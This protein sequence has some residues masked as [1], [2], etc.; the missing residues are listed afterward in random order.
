MKPLSFL[1]RIGLIVILA[2]SFLAGMSTPKPVSA[3]TITVCSSGCDYTTI[4][5][6]VDAANEGDEILVHAGTFVENVT[7]NKNLKLLS[8]EGRFSTTIEGISGVGALATITITGNTTN[9]QIGDLN[10]GF[11]IIGIDN[12]NPAVENAAVYFQGNHSGAIIRGN[13]IVANGD[14][15]LVT[16]WGATIS[17]FE[18]KENIFS[19]KTFVGDNPAG[20]GFGQQFSL[21]NVPRQLVAIGGGATGTGTTNI[22]FR[23]NIVNGIAGG[24]NSSGQPQ[25]NTLVTIDADNS[26]IEGNR[27]EGV[28]SRYATSLRARRPNTTIENNIFSSTGLL[29]SATGHIFLQNNPINADLIA[30]NTFDKGVYVYNTLGGTVGISISAAVIAAPA[31]NVIYVL[32]GIYTEQVVIEKDLTLMGSGENTII[33]SPGTL[34]STYLIGSN[35]YKPVILVKDA[36]NVILQDLV[37]DGDGKG[38]ANYRFIG[39]GYFNSGGLISNVEIKN[40]QDT[41]FSGTQHG[42]AL[43]IYNGDGQERQVE[44]KDSKLVD[45]QKNGTVFF[46][47]NLTV[48]FHDNEVIG[49][50]STFTTAQNGVQFSGG[51]TGDVKGNTIIG[52]A[53]TGA[54]WTASGILLYGVGNVTVEDNELNNCQTSIYLY[55]G[56]SVITNNVITT[57]KAGIG[58]GSYLTGIAAADPPFLPP[59]PVETTTSLDQSGSKNATNDVSI[60]DSGD[61]VVIQNNIVNGGGDDP[62]SVGI[63]A[64]AGYTDED[65]SFTIT[66]NNV[67]GWG[68]GLDISKCVS[69]CSGGEISSI[70]LKQ[71]KVHQNVFGMYTNVEVDASLNWWGTLSWYGYGTVPGIKDL[72]EVEGDGDVDWQPWR[73]EDLTLSLDIP[74]ITYADD[75]NA[76]KAEG[77]A[78]ANGGTFGYDAFVTIQ[79]ALNH[80]ASGGAVYVGAGNYSGDIQI[81]KAVTMVG[82]NRPVLDGRFWVN[83][84]DVTIQGFEI[85]NGIASTGVDQSG[86]YVSGAQNVT[87]RD[88]HLIGSWIGGETNFVGGR[89]ILTSGN[90]SNLVVEGNTIEKWVSGLY[91]NPTSGSIIVRNNEVRDNL[92]GAGTDG[93]GNVQFRNNYFRNNI[94][95]IG[96][97]SVGASFVTEENAFI[98]NTTAVNHYSGSQIKAERNWWSSPSGPTN[99]ANRGGS[100]QPVVGAVDFAPWLCDGSD[101]QPDQIGFQPAADAAG[102]TVTSAATRLVFTQYPDG[103]FENVPFATQPVVRAEDDDGNLAVNFNGAVLLVLANNSAGGALQ[104]SLLVNAVNGVATFSGVSISKAGED[105]RLAA[106]ATSLDTAVGG[107]FD[108]LPQNADLEVSIAASPNPVETGAALT[109]TVGVQNLGPLAASNLTLTVNLPSGVTFL[110]AG[111]TGWT[112]SQSGGVVTCTRF[113]LAAASNAPAVNITVNAPNQAGSI[114]ATASIAATTLDLVDSNNQASVDTLV[115]TIPETGG[116]TI[117][118]PLVKK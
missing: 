73:N 81:N 85:R 4:Q 67:F 30:S 8:T 63:G 115:V 117:Y 97:S 102:C 16:E 24:F 17:G 108:V 71:N 66:D 109:Y 2:F 42:V 93:Q 86:V 96:A 47:S 112:C 111:G 12:G 77:E 82:Q 79:D 19:G 99:S 31:S 105:Y 101:T 68:Y 5:A 91:L 69:G 118:L 1:F 29:T 103:G 35:I 92:A 75:D 50:G 32:P 33:R 80:V 59:S 14:L 26:V 38:N 10:K 78:G 76:G 110:N 83:A 49:K 36:S 95:G 64:W 114:T 48:N 72:F 107:Y 43:Y 94:E 52:I 28:T 13:E 53:Y 70:T 23:N 56:S 11:K 9:V 3:A 60:M 106:I 27:F 6:A 58:G 54:N 7:L 25:G 88:N 40:V 46:G 20:D 104:G 65:V 34:T 37:V 55:G 57:S 18:I 98:G 113:S 15:G 45:F 62:T 100:G 87:I 84:D 89:G 116:I 74:T 21:P 61:V 22:T 41:P 51:A 90:V 44:V 39:V